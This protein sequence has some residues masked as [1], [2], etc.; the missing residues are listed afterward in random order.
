M[1]QVSNHAAGAGGR[2]ALL[3]GLQRIEEHDERDSLTWKSRP[4]TSNDL[5]QQQDAAD[6]A[7]PV[8]DPSSADQRENWDSKLSF[9]LA[10]IGYAVGLGNVWRFP[11]LAQKNG[12]GPLVHSLIN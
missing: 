10:A 4:V 11:Y 8:G 12:G 2:S 9:L 5:Q 6:A 3:S 7:S 1:V